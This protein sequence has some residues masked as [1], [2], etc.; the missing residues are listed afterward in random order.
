MARK[1]VDP[2][3]HG[4]EG[5]KGFTMGRGRS[6]AVQASNGSMRP[7]DSVDSTAVVASHENSNV[8]SSPGTVADPLR[9]GSEGRDSAT[10]RGQPLAVPVADPVSNDS[11]I[12]AYNS[13]ITGRFDPLRK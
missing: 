7:A 2:P 10:G 11:T 12:P 1:V 9:S 8:R 13:K 3:H 5:S 4:N 6:M